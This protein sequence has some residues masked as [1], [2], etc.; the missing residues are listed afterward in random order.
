MIDW[1]ILFKKQRRSLPRWVIFFIDIVICVGSVLIAFSL[2]YNFRTSEILF[3]HNI[4]TSISVVLFFRIA[5]FFITRTYAGIVRYTGSQDAVRIAT[6]IAGSSLAIYVCVL[7]Y[8]FVVLMP[9]GVDNN[10]IPASVIIID[11]F[12]TLVAMTS[13]RLGYKLVYHQVRNASVEKTRVLIYG[14]GQMG[15]ITKRTLDQDTSSRF[16]VMGFVDTDRS[17]QGNLLEGAKIYGEV[18]VEGLL[19]KGNIDQI[20]IAVQELG[21]QKKKRIIE[22]GLAH[23]VIVSNIPP[24]TKWINGELGINQIKTV[25]IEDLL[26]RDAI[27]LDNQLV[28]KQL[29]GKVILVT[30]AAGSIGSEIARQIMHLNPAKLLLMDQA[31][32]PLYELELAFKSEYK[33]E[34]IHHAEFIVGDICD[35][36]RVREIF[37]LHK[38]DKV[39]HAA[40]YKHVPLMEQNPSQAVQNNVMGTKMLADLS[41]EYGVSR[42]V[43]VSTDKAVNPTNV[44][45]A[46]KRIAEI[47]VQS[48][49]NKLDRADSDHTRFI[50]T[51]FGNVLGSNGS[52]IPLFRKQIENGGPITVTHPDITR[53]F[54]TIPE[55]CQLVLEAG[56]MGKGGE[57]YI[58]D[59]GE[60]VKIIDL[61]KKMIQL[62]GLEEE[63]D[64][65]IRFTGLRPGEKI[66]EELLN[67]S[68]NTLPTHHPKIMVA[69]TRQYDFETIQDTINN[70]ILTAMTTDDERTVR[71]M[72]QIVPEYYSRNSVYELLDDERE[73]AAKQIS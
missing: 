37:K 62:S 18:D 68:E 35:E 17:K 52:V 20:I 73:K 7:T 32:T 53:F 67:D 29:R 56:A 40:A 36:S 61:A 38:P 50:T 51:R 69:R 30:G 42:F 27:Q 9:Q 22:M 8:Y 60:S 31:E 28:N 21:N 23:H 10:L 33:F 34:N 1:E 72:K 58:F 25:K 49:N 70:L 13:A 47:Y 65:K 12:I 54:M 6:A 39:F 66:Y 44:M 2:R 63:K 57:I 11:F 55:A 43:M 14:A 41:V 5:A 64:I 4:I 45:G 71:G 19:Q 48:L 24:V 46:S 15:I 26:G 59:M 16:K 3:N